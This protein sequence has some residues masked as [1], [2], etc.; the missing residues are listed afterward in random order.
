M[1]INRSVD[2]IKENKAMFAF[3]LFLFLFFFCRDN[4]GI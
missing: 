3:Y 4:V 2:K 1:R